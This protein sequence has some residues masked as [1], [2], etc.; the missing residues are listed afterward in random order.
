M[1]VARSALQ[2]SRIGQVKLEGCF[3]DY[4]VGMLVL[5]RSRP[6]RH[7]WGDCMS[8]SKHVITSEV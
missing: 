3:V 5:Q 1:H 4:G 7:G 6:L 8:A 2:W